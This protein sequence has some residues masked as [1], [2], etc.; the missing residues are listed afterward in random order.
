MNLQ[1]SWNLEQKSCLKKEMEKTLSCRCALFNF[2]QKWFQ[3][4]FDNFFNSG[5]QISQKCQ[6]TDWL[7][8]GI[9]E[10]EEGTKWNNINQISLEALFRNL[11]KNNY[12]SLASQQF[13]WICFHFIIWSGKMLVSLSNELFVDGWK[14][15]IMSGRQKYN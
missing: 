5:T 11:L 14:R 3:F 15:K 7:L 8:A 12:Q 10:E 13:V 4:R 6:G 2:I 9:G 1:L